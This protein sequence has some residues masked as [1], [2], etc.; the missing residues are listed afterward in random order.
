MRGT[1][2]D[3]PLWEWL[4]RFVDPKHRV[5]TEDDAY[6]AS[7]L[8]YTEGLRAEM[9]TVLDMYRFMHRSADSAE[10]GVHND[11]VGNF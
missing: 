2:E 8:C 6:A 4:R 1:A 5:L 3:L 11:S 10:E 7:R 9:T